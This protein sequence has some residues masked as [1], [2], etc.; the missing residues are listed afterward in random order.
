MTVTGTLRSGY[1]PENLAKMPG[2]Y[3]ALND[4]LNLEM[5]TN[6]FKDFRPDV[7]INCISLSKSILNQADPARL[8][9]VYSLL[10]HILSNLCTQFGARLVHI[11]SDGVF[12]GRTGNYSEQ[13]T[14]DAVDI[15]GRAKLLGEVTSE[16]AVSLRTS[17]IGH[18]ATAQ[19]GLISWFLKQSGHCRGYPEAIFSGFPVVVLAQIIRDYVI[20]NTALSGVYHVAS[21]P[22]SKYDL[23]QLV[24][25]IY[26][27]SV[28]VLPDTSVRIDRSLNADKFNAATNYKPPS[29]AML[30]ELMRE[31]FLATNK[32]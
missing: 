27:R 4:A 14:P 9:P 8:I 28:K 18:D 23:L 16:N 11:S 30:V 15:Y 5:L 24:S 25:E 12:S 19:N 20:P 29:W 22:I 31:D 17:M 2:N 21:D 13:D 32:Y 1:E 7:V 3:V 10:P 26:G 6:L